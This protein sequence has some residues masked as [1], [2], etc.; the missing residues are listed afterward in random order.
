M[1]QNVKPQ[2]DNF[3]DMSRQYENDGQFVSS[4]SEE[5]AAM[6]QQIDSTIH[7]VNQAVQHVSSLSQSSAD[8]SAEIMSSIDEAAVSMK[9][10]SDTVS[11]QVELSRKLNEMVMKFKI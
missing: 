8:G 5:L 9:S 10:M 6:A 1:I 2:L 4:M 3:M 7:E 11:G